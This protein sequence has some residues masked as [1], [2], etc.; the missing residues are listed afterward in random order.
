M[1]IL[2]KILHWILPSNQLKPRYTIIDMGNDLHFRIDEGHYKGTTLKYYNVQ[3]LED[4][5][6]AKLKFGYDIVR[7]DYFTEE[8]LQNDSKF[9]TIIGD[10]LQHYILNKA[11][12]VEAT[13]S[14]NSKEFGL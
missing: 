14:S 8:E 13:R 11:K 6:F 5:G 2:W 12:Q 4:E 1:E 10:I 7:T 3:I 9:V